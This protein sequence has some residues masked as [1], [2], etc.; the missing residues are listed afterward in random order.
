M[1][2][3]MRVLAR[4]VLAAGLVIFLGAAS[5]TYKVEGDVQYAPGYGYVVKVQRTFTSADGELFQN[6]FF[7]FDTEEAARRYVDR[8]KQDPGHTPDTVRVVSSSQNEKEYEHIS[9]HRQPL[10]PRARPDAIDR[11]T[12]PIPTGPSPR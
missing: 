10:P 12:P 7:I 3:V 8:V 11:I 2:N 9:D 4:A 5:C 6:L 1:T